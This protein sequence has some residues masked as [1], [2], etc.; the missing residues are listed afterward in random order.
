MSW[1]RIE[2][3]VRYLERILKKE[4]ATIKFEIKM[5][6]G[7]GGLSQPQ[8]TRDAEGWRTPHCVSRGATR[9]LSVNG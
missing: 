7:L 6:K 8:L 1:T 5:G 4:E 2:N 9:L 3:G